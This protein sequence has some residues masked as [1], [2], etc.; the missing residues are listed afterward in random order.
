[1]KRAEKLIIFLFKKYISL[2]QNDLSEMVDLS[3][4]KN[5]NSYVVDI[6]CYIQV[7]S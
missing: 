3:N 4:F 2:S 1:M 7:N 6:V 5:L